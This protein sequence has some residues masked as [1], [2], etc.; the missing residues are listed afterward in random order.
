MTKTDIEHPVS[1]KTAIVKIEI[2][3]NRDE[4]GFSKTMEFPYAQLESLPSA[5]EYALLNRV[6]K[7]VIQL[8]ERSSS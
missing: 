3:V 6:L 5:I 8:Q 2:Q 1:L 7:G 4:P